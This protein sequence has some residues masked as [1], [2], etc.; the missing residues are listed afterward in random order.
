LEGAGSIVK[1]QSRGDPQI[2]QADGAGKNRPTAPGF[3]EVGGADR[4]KQLFRLD[5]IDAHVV[6]YAQKG[7]AGRGHQPVPAI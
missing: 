1:R 3:D 6:V 2:S 7:R 4:R 5:I